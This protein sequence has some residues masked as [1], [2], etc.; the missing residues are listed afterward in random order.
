MVYTGAACGSGCGDRVYRLVG[1]GA[2]GLP[3]MDPL[4]LG[5]RLSAAAA[6]GRG[7]LPRTGWPSDPGLWR[8]GGGGG[9][10]LLLGLTLLGLSSRLLLLL[11]LL[12]LLVALS[13]GGLRGGR[14]TLSSRGGALSGSG[15]A[16]GSI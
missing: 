14:R 11:L 2:A 3:S 5:L 15:C 6:A 13:G 12:L 1:A 9:S 7:G 16:L 4:A 10:S 8:A